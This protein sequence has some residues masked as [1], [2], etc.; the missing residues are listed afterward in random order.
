[1]PLSTCTSLWHLVYTFVQSIDP[2][3]LIV[4]VAD[5]LIYITTRLAFFRFFCANVSIIS[6]KSGCCTNSVSMAS[7]DSAERRSWDIVVLCSFFILFKYENDLS[8]EALATGYLMRILEL[9]RI[10]WTVVFISI[11]AQ[12]LSC[13]KFL[14][15]EYFAIPHNKD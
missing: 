4:Y 13:I 5:F 1:M 10:Y 6:L 11:N 9:K 7:T 14:T 12:G 15:V 3:P 8:P 2:T